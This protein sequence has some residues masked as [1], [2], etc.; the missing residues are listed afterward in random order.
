MADGSLMDGGG[1][2]GFDVIE[3]SMNCQFVYQW[4]QNGA[5]M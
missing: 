1:V 3:C 2:G 5:Y 4:M